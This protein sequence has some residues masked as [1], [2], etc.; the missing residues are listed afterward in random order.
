MQD[1]D[2]ILQINLQLGTHAHKILR[3]NSIL[4]VGYRYYVDQ[5]AFSTNAYSWILS[6]YFYNGWRTTWAYHYNCTPSTQG[7]FISCDCSSVGKSSF[8]FL[9]LIWAYAW[10]CDLYALNYN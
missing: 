5:P 2:L 1:L 4:L 10:V 8:L 3:V 6:V 7:K 9:L